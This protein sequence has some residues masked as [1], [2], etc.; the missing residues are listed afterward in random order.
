[1]NVPSENRLIA[2]MYIWRVVKRRSRKPVMGMTTAIVSMNAVV[3]HCA[4]RA[5][6]PRS[7]MRCGIATP[8]VV[9]FRIATNAAARRS[10]MTRLSSG[11]RVFDGAAAARTVPVAVE[12]S[13]AAIGRLLRA[14][15]GGKATTDGGART[16]ITA[17]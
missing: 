7:L 16:T 17:T 3:S 6:I 14:L 11:R 4:W 5:L 12:M 15:G 8:I 1:M 13:V 9:S 2:A 10:Q